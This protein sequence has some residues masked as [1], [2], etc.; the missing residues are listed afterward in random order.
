MCRCVQKPPHT[1]QP[2]H[3]S[4]TSHKTVWSSSTS[5]LHVCPPPYTTQNI[6]REKESLP[7]PPSQNFIVYIIFLFFSWATITSA[8]YTCVSP[9]SHRAA[10]QNFF[11]LLV[12][13]SFCPIV[14]RLVKNLC[15]S[16][17][18]QRL[19]TLCLTLLCDNLLQYFHRLFAFLA[20]PEKYQWSKFHSFASSLLKQGGCTTRKRVDSDEIGATSTEEL[21]PNKF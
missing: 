10:F 1:E 21:L 12:T 13:A 2:I 16:S 4:V 11:R 19:K 5:I 7:F 15:Q 6:L 18:V 9:Q 3:K 8:D 20:S 17:S 14:T